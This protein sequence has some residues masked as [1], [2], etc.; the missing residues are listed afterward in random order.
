M[1]IFLSPVSDAFGQK[2]LDSDTVM[3]LFTGITI[4]ASPIYYYNHIKKGKATLVFNKPSF[5]EKV[6]YLNSETTF[7]LYTN[8][9]EYY[10][11]GT[12]MNN[13]SIRILYV[14]NKMIYF[15]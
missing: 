4:I 7:S 5:I 8:T 13:A 15:K 9:V 14:K 11:N 6:Q 10:E 1:K 12:P 2:N 3:L